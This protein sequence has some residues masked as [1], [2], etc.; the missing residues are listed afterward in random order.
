ML[1]LILIGLFL[2]GLLIVASMMGPVDADYQ[3][4]SPVYQE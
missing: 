2:A 4:L 1:W 3:E